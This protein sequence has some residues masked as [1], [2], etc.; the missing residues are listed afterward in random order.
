MELESVEMCNCK[1]HLCPGH[2]QA[3]GTL[4]GAG[5]GSPAQRVSAWRQGWEEALR[6]AAFC[7]QFFVVWDGL[8]YC[9][10]VNIPSVYPALPHTPGC[11]RAEAET[12]ESLQSREASQP[13]P[14]WPLP[15]H[16]LRIG[17]QSYRHPITHRFSY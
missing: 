16:L 11:V 9:Q 7:G 2:V 6:G 3:D 5:L 10:M 13:R 1:Q 17:P 4:L 12:T 8:V 14:T 15:L